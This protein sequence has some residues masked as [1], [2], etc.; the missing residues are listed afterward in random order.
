MN[1]YNYMSYEVFKNGKLIE[2]GVYDKEKVKDEL[3]SDFAA[4]LFYKT[5]KIKERYYKKIEVTWT[6]NFANDTYKT[7]RIYEK[8]EENANGTIR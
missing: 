6:N 5:C 1:D 4:N 2:T 3:I 7:I 8:K